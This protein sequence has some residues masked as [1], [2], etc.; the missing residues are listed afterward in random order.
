[1][2]EASLEKWNNFLLKNNELTKGNYG[3][4]A[5][6]KDIIPSL[7]C[8]DITAVH[9]YGNSENKEISCFQRSDQNTSHY[10]VKISKTA[11]TRDF[12]TIYYNNC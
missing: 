5:S 10:K 6:E 12:D 3:F 9:P 4:C 2:N 7:D 8:C 1:L 11:F